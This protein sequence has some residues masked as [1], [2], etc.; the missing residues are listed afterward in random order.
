MAAPITA[1]QK[2]G[3]VEIDL[4]GRPAATIP[5]VAAIDVPRAGIFGRMTGALDYLIWGRD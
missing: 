4:Q 5:L 2:L 3:E 1:G